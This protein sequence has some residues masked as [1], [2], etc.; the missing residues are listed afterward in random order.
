[1]RGIP[2][3][4]KPGEW[5]YEYTETQKFYRPKRYAEKCKG[6]PKKARLVSS[7]D[8]EEIYEY[9]KPIKFRSAIRQNKSQNVWYTETKV[10]SLIDDKRE[11]L[12]DG[13]SYPIYVYN[14]DDDYHK[15]FET[16]TK[17]LLTGACN[18]CMN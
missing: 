9:E 13:S 18:Y 16:K 8:I 2:I 4:D 3:G 12:S 1:V 6:V 15:N 10:I 14:V 17:N 5:G 7:N 11:W